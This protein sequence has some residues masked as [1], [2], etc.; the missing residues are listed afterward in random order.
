M[1]AGGLAGS[2]VDHVWK[3]TASQGG[4][5]LLGHVHLEAAAHRLHVGRAVRV[6]QLILGDDRPLGRHLVVDVLGDLKPLVEQA[7]VAGLAAQ[8]DAYLFAR[9]HEDDAP[10]LR[11]SPIRNGTPHGA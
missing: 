11:A 3:Y 10:L 9:A 1:S 6:G 4:P 7:D 2:T 8:R 5:G